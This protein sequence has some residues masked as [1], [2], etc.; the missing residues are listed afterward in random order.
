[1]SD[2]SPA[3]FGGIDLASL[4]PLLLYSD[5]A[6]GQV[7]RAAAGLDDG[8][9]DRAMEIGRGSFRR[10]LL[11]LYAG[12][13]VWLQRWQGKG[14]TPWPDE[15]EAASVVTLAERFGRTRGERDTFLK[16]LTPADTQRRL[17]YRDSRGGLFAATLG[18]MLLQAVI[19]SIHHRAQLVNMLRRLGIAAPELDYIMWV[20]R[21]A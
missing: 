14:E 9:L 17:S 8:Q 19:H 16:L 6:N 11:H 4:R 15:S 5:W 2:Q 18:D 1:M 13:H 20:R 3:A 12:E 21:P 10:T 7:L